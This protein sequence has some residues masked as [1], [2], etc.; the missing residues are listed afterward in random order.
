MRRAGSGHQEERHSS[1]VVSGALTL[2]G[3]GTLFLHNTYVLSSSA[4]TGPLWAMIIPPEAGD[5]S[6]DAVGFENSDH[7][8]A[9]KG[10]GHR[11][12][13]MGRQERIGL[14][15][16]SAKAGSTLMLQR[17]IRA[18]GLGQGTRL[19]VPEPLPE[20]SGRSAANVYVH[21]QYAR[22]NRRLPNARIG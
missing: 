9:T 13:G 15:Q 5:G 8:V 2:H 18:I 21:V 11:A 17:W 4:P 20:I 7:A 6:H 10:R 19:E 16:L 3:D 22:C 14:K 12:V 1:V